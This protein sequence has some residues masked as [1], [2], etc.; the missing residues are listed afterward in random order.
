MTPARLLSFGASPVFAG[1][2]LLDMLY[3]TEL[4]YCSAMGGVGTGGMGAMYA[5]MSIF[6]ASPWLSLMQREKQV[7]P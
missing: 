6:H 3:G 2:A 4:P 5:L 1:M 7:A